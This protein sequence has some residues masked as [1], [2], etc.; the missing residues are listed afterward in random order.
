M[1][2]GDVVAGR[3]ELVAVAGRGNMGVIWRALDREAAGT[4]V[5]LKL[6]RFD[7]DEAA[8]ARFAREA[9]V[10]ASLRHPNI[11]RYVAHGDA[12]AGE[13]YLAM[14][15]L[16]GEDLA[17]RIRRGPLPIAESVEIA[18]RVAEALAVAH[19]RGVVHR[20]IK[21]SNVFLSS[22]PGQ[23]R[24]LDFGIARRI[25]EGQSP[26]GT[27][28]AVGTLGYMAPEQARGERHIDA[29]ADVF[30]LGSVLYRAITGRAAFAGDNMMSILVK[31][32]VEEPPLLSD[33]L[34]DVPD[35]L[36]ALVGRMLSKD[37]SLRPANGAAL[38]S[39]LQA[40]DLR[41]PSVRSA[42]E[43]PRA[44][45]RGEQ[46]LMSIVLAKGA[47]ARRDPASID[48]DFETGTAPTV[49]TDRTA[50]TALEN[51]VNDASA[52][53]DTLADG[54][55]IAVV[56]DSGALTDLA[57]RAASVAL[58]LRRSLPDAAMAMATGR[59]D[60]RGRTPAGEVVDRV[61]DLARG[62]RPGGVRL[63]DVTAGLLDLRYVISGDERGLSLL[64]ERERPRTSRTLLGKPTPFVGRE[65]SMGALAGLYDE[66][67]AESVARV[68]LVT[69][70]A[71][72]GKSRLR[73][74]LVNKLAAHEV[75]PQVWA[76]RGDE[77]ARG[78][79][80]DL[81][82]PT[83]RDAAGIQQ[84]EPRTT[85]QHKLRARVARSVPVGARERV[86][87]FLGELLG[88]GASDE[89]NV[90]L[91][92]A[93]TDAL[94][95]G[96]QLRAAWQDF[97]RAETTTQPVLLVLEDL[98]WGDLPSIRLL[99]LALR[100]LAHQ[101][102]MILATARPDVA[103]IFPDLWRDR[104]VHEVRL[105]ALS[106][107]AAE[108][109]VRTVLG[110]DVA[111]ERISRIVTLAEGNALGL[112]EVVRAAATGKED[113]VPATITAMAMARLGGLDE[114]ARRVLRAASIFGQVFWDGAVANLL[115]ARGSEDV[116]RWLEWLEER[117]VVASLGE[118]RFAGQR[119]YTFRHVVASQAAYAM[120]TDVD[121]VLGHRLAAEW[122]EGAGERS[123][124]AIAAHYESGDSAAQA[125]AWYVRAAEQALDG[126]DFAAAIERAERAV[127]LGAAGTLLG[128][129]RWVQSWAHVWRNEN[130]ALRTHTRQAMD[131]LTEGSDRSWDACGLLLNVALR[132]G[133]AEAARQEVDRI[134]PALQEPHPS[135]ALVS[136]AARAALV[137]MVLGNEA[138]ERLFAAIEAIETRHPPATP[139]ARA[140][141]T[142]AR[143]TAVLHANEH[144][145]YLE[146]QR[147][148][149]RL[150]EEAG[151]VR[152][153]SSARV[154]IGYA[155]TL[156]GDYAA[157]ESILREAIEEA[158][159]LGLTNIDA[160][161]RHNLGPVLQR[162]GRLEE[163]EAIERAV[164]DDFVR[165]GD[166]RLVGASRSYLASILFDRGDAE[167]AE[168]EARRAIDELA[169][170]P[171]LRPS[172][173]AVLANVLLAKQPSEALAAAREAVSAV[174]SGDVEDESE[175]RLVLA[176]ALHACGDTEAASHAITLARDRVLAR[177]SKIPNGPARDAFLSLVP[178][179]AR[180]LTLA[181]AW[182][183]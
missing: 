77:R 7:G 156:L 106:P 136:A 4:H 80:F 95:M 109:L 13:R 54:S 163:A 15:W 68:A 46:R 101:P 182:K 40:L 179:H 180:T 153:A 72:I 152:Q 55:V 117:E 119:E 105:D 129:A 16:E 159:H 89:E 114:D 164:I 127:S 45:G 168:R 53:I 112:E 86:T 122:L 60:E 113:D 39:E 1:G 17:S 27:G 64:R 157:A 67:V 19:A 134:L 98:H 123:A 167:N 154:S 75:P 83:I 111:P 99:D 143:G 124:V 24:V 93:R 97:L 171:T 18:R 33:A 148:Q 138:G 155:L 58:A 91:R 133:D 150:W 176:E 90:M 29:R 103:D 94:L 130:D 26:T 70:P 21:P 161:A 6:M 35:A 22:E 3:F 42:A 82:R 158:G 135:D 47:F 141:V 173:L 66:V 78:G 175:I 28:V 118:G 92:A 48:V 128:V 57:A 69:G 140:W 20:D 51:T 125:A 56:R 120:L 23:V 147:M 126:N 25:E 166:Q 85:Q 146:L 142:R 76:S 65:R 178:V 2:P 12:E 169:A 49:S 37:P 132:T 131:A 71:G 174:D 139:S 170:F 145:R 38:L 31:V 172:A 104:S 59:A 74:E 62:A 102:W 88:Q 34:P 108:K 63:D 61:V 43:H 11:V 110:E 100:N 9:T 137:S 96:D 115:G 8:A 79:A 41:A 32:L 162:L 84:D 149:L 116:A 151:D 14:E 144:A 10:L 81:I 183:K 30:A 160:Q 50:L 165:A 5:A 107:R 44:L 177:A 121:R 73:Y 52:R 36:A 87:T 181:D